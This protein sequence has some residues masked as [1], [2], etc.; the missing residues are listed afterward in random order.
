MGDAAY[1]SLQFGE[2]D[3]REIVGDGKIAERDI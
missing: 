2:Q 1:C 3:I